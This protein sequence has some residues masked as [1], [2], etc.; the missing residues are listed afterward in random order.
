MTFN[1]LSARDLNKSERL[2]DTINKLK[3][4][5]YCKIRTIESLIGFRSIFSSFESLSIKLS[6]CVTVWYVLHVTHIST[7]PSPYHL[8]TILADPKSV[9]SS[10]PPPTFSDNVTEYDVLFLRRPFSGLFLSNCQLS[11]QVKVCLCCIVCAVL[12]TRHIY[13]QFFRQC[14][15]CVEVETRWGNDGKLSNTLKLELEQRAQ[16]M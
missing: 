16:R 14:N 6:V 13:L 10:W 5:I 11:L 9:I 1:I 2:L 12:E 15:G 3:N 4:T 7:P 8:V